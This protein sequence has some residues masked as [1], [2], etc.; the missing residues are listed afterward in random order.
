MYR[1][2][3]CTLVICLAVAACGGQAEP[4][5]TEMA[6]LVDQAVAATLT[7]QA[8][9]TTPIPEDTPPA[10][11][12]SVPPSDTP[13]L[14]MNTPVPPTDTPV[15]P[16]DTPIPPTET[17]TPVPPTATPKAPTVN[18]NSS[19]RSGPGTSYDT[20]AESGLGD[21][22]QVIARDDTG[23]WLQ[24]ALASGAT[25]W[26]AASLIDDVPHDVPVAATIPPSP[27][28]M[29][30]IATPKPNG[31]KIVIVTVYNRSKAEYV[32]I[33]NQGDAAV[34]MGGWHLYG[35]KDDQSLID[36]YFFPPGF[37]LQP[38]QL[39]RLHSGEGDTHNPP[40]DIYWTEKCVWNNEG[41]TVY[42]RD[43]AGNLVAEYGY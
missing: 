2:I 33:A 27:T 41:E 8:P 43:A 31:D 11:A 37:I 13:V 32:D 34:D 18:Q 3:L 29:P 28:P 14:P 26:M 17:P 20:V 38:G 22:V 19:I 40:E 39:V 6:R 7:A 21:A 10:T 42:L 9:A 30:P 23:D 35:S 5:P 25:G 1:V 4:E 24:V 36:D 12:T 16:T 15:P